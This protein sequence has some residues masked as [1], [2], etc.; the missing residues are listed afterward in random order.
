MVLIDFD[1]PC[2]LL[3]SYYMCDDSV[4]GGIWFSRDVGKLNTFGF[5][6]VE[7]LKN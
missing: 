2:R 5:V 6:L 1:C 4:C 3:E 7:K